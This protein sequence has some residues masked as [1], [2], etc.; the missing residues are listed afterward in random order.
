MEDE[1]A[2]V[3]AYTWLKGRPSVREDA[4]GSRPSLAI[5]RWVI[6]SS[7]ESMAMEKTL[8]AHDK[9]DT[10]PSSPF[11]KLAES[12]FATLDLFPLGNE[13]TLGIGIDSDDEKMERTGVSTGVNATDAV[14]QRPSD[15]VGSALSPSSTA[16]STRLVMVVRSRSPRAGSTYVECG[17]EGGGSGFFPVLCGCDGDVTSAVGAT[18]P[19]RWSDAQDYEFRLGWTAVKRRSQRDP[20]RM[21]PV[22]IR[23]GPSPPLPPLPVSRRQPLTSLEIFNIETERVPHASPLSYLNPKDRHIYLRIRRTLL[24]L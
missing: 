17:S 2:P 3:I 20:R 12:R 7:C 4:I 18:G 10:T 23:A 22:E 5:G 8:G 11:P 19:A 1:R 15:V 24:P 6:V 14:G 16:A 21:G 9:A 13:R